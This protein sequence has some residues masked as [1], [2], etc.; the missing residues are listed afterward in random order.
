MNKD[1]WN[2]DLCG[3]AAFAER[4]SVTGGEAA[5]WAEDGAVPSIQKGCFLMVTR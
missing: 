1:K 2:L 4:C 5:Q 3:I